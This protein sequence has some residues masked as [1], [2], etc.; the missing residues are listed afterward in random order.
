MLCRKQTIHWRNTPKW[1]K[2]MF[3]TVC[4]NSW[5]KTIYVFRDITTRSYGG[6]REQGGED[7]EIKQWLILPF[8]E[9]DE[10][11]DG[12][13]TDS[14]CLHEAPV[15]TLLTP[16][17]TPW[18]WHYEQSILLPESPSSK[19]ND[20]VSPWSKAST[21]KSPQSVPNPSPSRVL[22]PCLPWEES[23]ACEFLEVLQKFFHKIQH[24]AWHNKYL[25]NWTSSL[26]EQT[27]GIITASY[28]LGLLILWF[29][30]WDR[31]QLPLFP[32]EVAF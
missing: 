18:I 27:E 1:N 16:R 23:L 31:S 3:L 24:S 28:L 20:F 17:P 19:H 32:S 15:F 11:N 29:T 2:Y 30:T 4:S 25:L 26:Q 9:P 13:Y 10:Y 6:S 12:K 14:P 5:S 22:G 21:C 8:G 7:C